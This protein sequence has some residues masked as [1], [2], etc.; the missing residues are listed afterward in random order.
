VADYDTQRAKGQKIFT[1]AYT[2]VTS[3]DVFFGSGKKHTRKSRLLTLSDDSE[4]ILESINST[5]YFTLHELSINLTSASQVVI[6]VPAR[7]I[8]LS[9]GA[10]L[11]YLFVGF[12]GALI[13]LRGPP[14]TTFGVF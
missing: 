2:M 10:S 14:F 1:G 3:Y 5:Y 13:L 11:R 12:V 9:P 8:I 6:G 7:T 4:I